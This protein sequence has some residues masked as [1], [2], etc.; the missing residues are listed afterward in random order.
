MFSLFGR[1]AQTQ[2]HAAGVREGRASQ[3]EEE[4]NRRDEFRRIELEGC[5]DHPVIIVPNE[6]DNPVVGFGK[7]IVS[8]GRSNVLLVH[9]YISNEEV[10]CGG[11]RMDFSEQRLDICLSL[12]PYQLWAITAHNS[13]GN[14]DFDKPK[15]GERWAKE[16]I[17]QVLEDNGFFTRWN[18]FKKSRSHPPAE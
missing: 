5:V 3:Q 6:W 16:K 12:D 11:V 1:K 17:M 9:N 15:S 8:V 14:E 7:S 4:R 10:I 18:E 2:A 13:V